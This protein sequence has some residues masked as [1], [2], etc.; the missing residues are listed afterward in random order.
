MLFVQNTRNQTWVHIAGILIIAVNWAFN[1]SW[2]VDHLPAER[3]FLSDLFEGSF[4]TY[5]IVSFAIRYWALNKGYDSDWVWQINVVAFLWATAVNIVA[6][7]WIA[8]QIGGDHEA[9]VA[10]IMQTFYIAISAMLTLHPPEMRKPHLAA[11]IAPLASVIPIFLIEPT[12]THYMHGDT[13]VRLF[14]F[15]ILMMLIRAAVQQSANAAHEKLLKAQAA[16]VASDAARRQLEV[17]QAIEVERERLMGEVHDGI[18]SS[19]VTALAVAKREGHSKPTI[20]LL[21]KAISELKITVDSLDPMEGDLLA[22]LGNLRH[23]LEPGL[24]KAG[25]SVKWDVQLV[26]MLPWLD[27]ANA[28]QLL[29]LVQEA[30]SN[31]LVHSNATQLVFRCLPAMKDGRE[32][33]SIEIEDNG[34]GFDMQSNVKGGKGLETMQ[35][36]ATALQGAFDCQSVPGA[37]TKLTLWLPLQRG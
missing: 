12:R 8:A 36:R 17:Q 6:Q 34:K 11:S 4:L 22:L 14:A 31:A 7:A 3:V 1:H 27:P 2:A 16:L 9:R 10:T 13:A 32:G 15:A 18:G 30:A 28:L 19:L 26:P 5:A 24:E 25:L 33:I 35:A 37:G 20:D 29:R 23:R 21:S